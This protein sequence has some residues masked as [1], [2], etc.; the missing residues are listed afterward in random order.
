MKRRLGKKVQEWREIAERCLARD[1]D[2]EIAQGLLKCANDAEAAMN[3][4]RGRAII[5]AI[6]LAA[7]ALLADARELLAE[8]QADHSTTFTLSAPR[9]E[10]PF[11]I[12]AIPLEHNPEE[13]SGD[14]IVITSS[15]ISASGSNEGGGASAAPFALDS[16]DLGALP[17]RTTYDS[18]TN[19]SAASRIFQDDPIVVPHEERNAESEPVS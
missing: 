2:S 9:S 16:D 15:P 4:K 5:A 7:T 13:R 11:E 3:S 10:W 17:F 6:V 18:Y 14:T 12:P 19:L 8:R 1:P